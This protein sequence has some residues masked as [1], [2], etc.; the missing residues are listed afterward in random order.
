MDDDLDK[1]AVLEPVTITD[2]ILTSSTI[3]E[4]SAGDPAAWSAVV[5]Y[6]VGDR[7]YRA[8]THRIYRALL[9]G[10]NSSPPEDTPLRWFDVDST[11]RWACLDNKPGAPTV[12]VAAATVTYVLHP[13]PVDSLWIGGVDSNNLSITVR[14][15]PGG[16][17]VDS[18]TDPLEG[19]EPPD[20]YEHF[21]SP[22]QPRRDFLVNSLPPYADMEIT[23]S[24]SNGSAPVTLSA[25]TVGM[26]TIIAEAVVGCSAKPRT[27]ATVKLDENGNN[28]TKPGA[29]TKDLTL[30]GFIENIDDA[31]AAVD[32]I[33]RLLT[34]NCLWS[35]STKPNYRALRTWGL[36][37]GQVDYSN[38]TSADV[39]IAVQGVLSP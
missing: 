29:A 12:G 1:I 11:N 37:S 18:I 39:Q 23:V 35:A 21:F 16:P 8:T 25:L 30:K 14:S 6:A 24:L 31:D 38:P 20:Y 9:A 4:P 10:V 34:T 17:I 3:A 5:T 15:S 36:A 2:S 33:T 28:A 32:T 27:F 7:V 26:T 22:F 19:S 13:G